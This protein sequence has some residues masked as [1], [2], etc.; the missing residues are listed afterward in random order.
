MYGCFIHGVLAKY[1]PVGFRFNFTAPSTE[2]SAQ[3]QRC[4]WPVLHPGWWQ[5]TV[6]KQQPEVCCLRD[7][8]AGIGNMSPPFSPTDMGVNQ[9]FKH[10]RS[11]AKTKRQQLPLQQ[12]TSSCCSYTRKCCCCSALLGARVLQDTRDGEEE[13]KTL[14]QLHSGAP[15]LLSSTWGLWLHLPTHPYAPEGGGAEQ[16]TL[17]GRCVCSLNNRSVLPQGYIFQ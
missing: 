10:H 12:Q 2:C 6:Q 5:H 15:Y 8:E 11:E 16:N 4:N 1:L 7:G 17:L 3:H 9:P 14:P 13:S